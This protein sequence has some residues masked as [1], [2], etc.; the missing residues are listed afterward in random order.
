[1]PIQSTGLQLRQSPLVALLMVN[2]GLRRSAIWQSLG[3]VGVLL[4]V[5]CLAVTLGTAGISLVDVWRILLFKIGLWHGPAPD[6]TDLYIVWGVRLP[7]A[8]GALAVGGLLG[9][10]GAAMQGLFRNPLADPGLAGVSAG[11]TLGAV[12]GIV[13]GAA[14]FSAWWAIW[15]F[16]LLPLLA[17]VG[18]LCATVLVYRLGSVGGTT[19]VTT[20]LL[21]GIAIQALCMAVV[22][23]L[24][25]LA[26]DAQVRSITFW[27]FGSLAPATWGTVQV[28]LPLAGLLLVLF[29]RQA[30]GLDLLLLGEAECAHLGLRPQVLKRRLLLLVTAAVGY[31]TA[32]FG[33]IGFIGLVVPH[34]VRLIWGPGHAQLLP[35]AAWLGA[36]LLLLADT[37]ARSAWVIELPVGVVTSALGAPFFLWMLRR[38][39]HGNV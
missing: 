34:L 31:C 22:G 12:V 39:M 38:Q 23:L 7:R 29:W 2:Q 26:S 3:A 21:A 28:L 17:F 6:P 33:I 8:L 9:V 4:L 35:R 36:A 1:M 37:L 30:R 27:T 5:V 20:L 15:G 25:T 11:A 18:A 16:A 24:M 19:P 32:F 10:A 13:L 14:L